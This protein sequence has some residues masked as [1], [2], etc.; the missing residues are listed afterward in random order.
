M[1][2]TVDFFWSYRC[3]ENSSTDIKYKGPLREPPSI[4]KT[5]KIWKSQKRQQNC[6]HNLKSIQMCSWV[7]SFLLLIDKFNECLRLVYD[8]SLHCF[9]QKRFFF[10]YFHAA[11][12]YSVLLFQSPGSLHHKDVLAKYTGTTN[13][14]ISQIGSNKQSATRNWTSAMPAKNSDSTW[15]SKRSL[16][17]SVS[18]KR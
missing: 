7:Y 6:Q 3:D 5:T 15:G 13:G 12:I 16:D 18:L 11:F 2:V 8:R 4:A 17:Y 1:K 14:K 9:V 10:Y